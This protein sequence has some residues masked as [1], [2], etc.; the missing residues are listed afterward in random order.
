M[1]WCPY[2][3]SET[4]GWIDRLL[5][6]DALFEVSTSQEASYLPGTGGGVAAVAGAGDAASI[7]GGVGSVDRDQDEHQDQRS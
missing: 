6:F 1:W 3:T 2:R 7:G 5:L 4:T